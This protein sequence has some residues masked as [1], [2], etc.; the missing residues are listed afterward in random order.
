[1][2]LTPRQQA[3][4]DAYNGDG[5][6]AARAAGYKGTDAVLAVT[7]SRLLRT[8]KVA[9]EIRS[10]QERALRPLIATREERQR[11]WSEMMN[12]PEFEPRDRLKAS[13]LLG[14]SEADFTEKVDHSGAVSIA[15]VN[16]YAEPR[17]G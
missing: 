15:V 3:F 4:V 16:P 14:K 6:A 1:M 11:F 2:A 17:R 9:K 12:S 10:R 7:A 8:A 5:T 13:E